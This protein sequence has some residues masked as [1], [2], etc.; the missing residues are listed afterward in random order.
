ML[1]PSIDVDSLGHGQRFRIV[2]S[3]VSMISI[4]MVPLKFSSGLAEQCKAA[5][6][7]LDIPKS[8]VL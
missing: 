5:V 8:A 1:C 4:D 3:L 7:L 2:N 6:I